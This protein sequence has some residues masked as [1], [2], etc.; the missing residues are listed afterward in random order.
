MRPVFWDKTKL[1]LLQKIADAARKHSDSTTLKWAEA[2]DEYSPQ[3]KK[4]LPGYTPHELSK[5]WSKYR[6]VL[7]GYCY[8]AGCTKKKYGDHIYCK[9]CGEKNKRYVV[10]F[11]LGR[12]LSSKRYK[13]YGKIIESALRELSKDELVKILIDN[14]GSLPKSFR[15]SFLSDKYVKEIRDKQRKLF[16]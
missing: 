11:D 4:L 12:I 6:K 2:C 15:G 9:E 8:A 13:Q 1:A 16:R 3:I 14:F 10:A 5:A 7:K